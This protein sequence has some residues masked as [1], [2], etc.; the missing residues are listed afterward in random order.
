MIMAEVVNIH[1]VRM[2]FIK[3]NFQEIGWTVLMEAL[4]NAPVAKEEKKKKSMIN[5]M[6]VDLSFPFLL[7]EAAGYHN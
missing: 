7:Q 1:E 6:I 4:K 5:E 3:Q 2:L